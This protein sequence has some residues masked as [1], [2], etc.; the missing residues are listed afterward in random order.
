MTPANEE[1]Y[2]TWHPGTGDAATWRADGSHQNGATFADAVR[3]YNPCRAIAL[4][5]EYRA[6]HRRHTGEQATYREAHRSG[7][8]TTKF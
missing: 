4:A 2:V 8:V 3:R 7:A 1:G 5:R 6:A